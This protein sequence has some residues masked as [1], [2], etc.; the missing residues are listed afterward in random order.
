M[1]AS[2]GHG[3]AHLGNRVWPY[4]A[5]YVQTQT[6]LIT[7]ATAS[8]VFH[9]ATCC[10]RVRPSLVSLYILL[11]PALTPARVPNSSESAAGDVVPTSAALLQD[12]YGVSRVVVSL[13]LR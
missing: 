1:V 5:K 8:R 10:P 6:S 9:P 13:D 11:T 3:R 2:G 7:L 4:R 12:V